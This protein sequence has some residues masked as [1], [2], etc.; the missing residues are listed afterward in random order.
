MIWK[1]SIPQ[2]P[3]P[4]ILRETLKDY[5]EIIQDIQDELNDVVMSP[6]S[7]TPIIEQAIW[8]VER[9]FTVRFS[10][11]FEVLKNAEQAGD[12]QAIYRAKI[13]VD[14]V[15]RARHLWDLEDLREYFQ[16]YKR[17]SE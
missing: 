9:I 17:V 4:Q 6:L 2:P 16:I 11:A 15:S 5:P 14:A 1:N 3:V 13:K 7:G 8:A 10:D 12:S